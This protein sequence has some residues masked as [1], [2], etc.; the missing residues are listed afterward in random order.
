MT[1]TVLCVIVH[2]VI[3]FSLTFRPGVSIHEQVVYAVKKAI[4][5]GQ[6]RPGAQFPSVRALSK[7]LKINPNTAY[8]VV[9]VLTAEGLLEVLPGIGT[10][11]ASPASSTPAER[12]RLLGDEVEHLVVEAKKMGLELE[13]VLS[14]VSEHWDALRESESPKEPAER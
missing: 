10:V 13:D 9:S 2:T 3:P 14:A 1:V 5:S 8:K 4:V 11:V 6:L 12:T 7:G